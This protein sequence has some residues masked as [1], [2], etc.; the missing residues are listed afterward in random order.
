MTA[1]PRETTGAPVGPAANRIT[2]S[3]ALLIGAIGV[4]LGPAVG[5]EAWEQAR[6]LEWW[7]TPLAFTTVFGTCL[8]LAALS[9]SISPRAVRGLCGA[10]CG[11]IL[12]SIVVLPLAIRDPALHDDPFWLLRTVALGAAGVLVWRPRVATAVLV[13]VVGGGALANGWLQGGVRWLPLVLDF[14]RNFG[15]AGLLT[16]GLFTVVRAAATLDEESVRAER[17]AAEVAAADAKSRE[18]A[19]FSAIIH[20]EVMSTLLDASRGRDS[21]ALGR[22]AH[23]A[24]GR[25]D[26]FRRSGEEGGELDAFGAIG[27]LRATVSAINP[28]ITFR[29][30]RLTGFA[31]LQVPADVGDAIA[32]ALAEAVRNSLR[33]GGGIGRRVR[34]EVTVTVGTGAL[35]VEMRDDGAGFDA[36]TVPVHRLGVRRSILARMADLP[37][38]AAFV[39]SAP[40]QG[41]T[42]TL[43]W[44]H[45][46]VDEEQPDARPEVPVGAHPPERWDLRGL[47][48][49]RGAQGA[50]VTAVLLAT[51]ASM[52]V[53]N[54]RSIP[55]HQTGILVAYAAIA[56]AAVVTLAID[57]DPF[58]WPV[59]AAV[60]A[61][62][63]V[64]AALAY[65]HVG[66]EQVHEFVWTI[67]A[68]S[69][70]L[71]FLAVRGR[72]G[73]AT[74]SIV[75]ATL[76]AV[77]ALGLGVRGVALSMT[78]LIIVVAGTLMAAIARSNLRALRQLADESAARAAAQA[79]LRAQGEERA[80]Q[81]ERLDERA[82]PM[83]ERIAA[84]DGLT[85]AERHESR[86]L[87]AELRDSLRAP[88]LTTGGL[89][90][91]TRGARS[92]GVEVLLLDDGGLADAPEALTATVLEEVAQQLDKA[93]AGTITVRILPRG[94]HVLATILVDAPDEMRRIEIGHDGT[95]RTLVDH[96]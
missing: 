62:G 34:R 49:L 58:P 26:E 40:G 17:D 15:I 38:G 41:T 30:K 52:S 55:G 1:A 63:P 39:E 16:W 64:S 93:N 90:A 21:T 50:L 14:T 35:R 36:E 88:T 19:R 33:H 51:I 65:D 31:R 87:E 66:P 2:R 45:P 77:F 67:Y 84:G 10:V 68:F 86:V 71:C 78:P 74:A 20:D 4:L 32:A 7:W 27:T 91:A 54:I 73:Y 28:G 69:V 70:V 59:A 23:R 96:G 76:V 75:A 79:T 29:A 60:A 85:E 8:V 61:V 48:G 5:R 92:R 22:L 37:G 46:S 47:L 80:R 89:V 18:R 3:A 83:L 25:F 9:F 95:T 94:R 24:L 11:G 12:L 42:V 81:L 44:V 6:F 56:V 82:R 53:S 57:T 72:S 13:L 43:V